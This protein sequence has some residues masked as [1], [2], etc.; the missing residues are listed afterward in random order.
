[1]RLIFLILL[2]W[3]S[4]FKT[5]TFDELNIKKAE[6]FKELCVG[7]MNFYANCIDF[8]S[9]VL[10][11]YTGTIIPKSL[12]GTNEYRATNDCFNG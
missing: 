11:T 9:N 4:E 5:K 8:E 3:P 10:S 7:F 6:T 12:F 2:D 1:M